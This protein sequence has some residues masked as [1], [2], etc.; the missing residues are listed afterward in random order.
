MKKY[1]YHITLSGVT[2]EQLEEAAKLIKGKATSIDL[3]KDKNS[4]IDRMVTKYQKDDSIPKM[5]KKALVLKHNGFKV[6]RCKLECMYTDLNEWMN[7]HFNESEY[8]EVHIKVPRDL[9]FESSLMQRSSNQE[10]TETTFLNAR[11]YNRKQ[12][13][14][15]K[16]EY[17]KLE[18]MGAV[19][20]CHF[21]QVIIDTNKQLDSWWA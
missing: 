8:G 21:E 12:S 9:V 15:F 11:V 3:V 16:T 17:E 10:D 6:I 2:S 1:H 4:Q 19:L 14:D 5:L 7:C 20:S 18:K 13:L